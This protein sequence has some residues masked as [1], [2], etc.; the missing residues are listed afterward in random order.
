MNTNSAKQFK[1]T[2]NF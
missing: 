1:S 2:A